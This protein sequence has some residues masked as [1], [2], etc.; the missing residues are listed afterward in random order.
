MGNSNN[1]EKEMSSELL[2]TIVTSGDYEKIALR[3]SQKT[4]MLLVFALIL[5]VVVNVVL[6]A[7]AFRP[8]MPKYF[9]VDSNMRVTQLIPLNRPYVSDGMLTNFATETIVN[10]LTFGFHDYEKH[11]ERVRKNYSDRGFSSLYKSLVDNGVIEAV[12]ES[13]VNVNTSLRESAII[14][15]KNIVDGAVTWY[16]NVP[17]VVTYEGASGPV[18]SQKLVAKVV[19]Q[20]VHTVVSPKAIQVKQVVFKVS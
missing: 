10:T 7:I 19:V 17:I 1:I 14:A 8:A 12:V 6:G 5:S 15:K 4:V 9:A 16:V 2:E 18:K 20:R 13:R 11:M 3:S